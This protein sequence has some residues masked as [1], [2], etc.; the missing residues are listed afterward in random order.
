[1]MRRDLFSPDKIIKKNNVNSIEFD[2][3]ET[4]LIVHLNLQQHY[5]F[6]NYRKAG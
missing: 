3:S 4:P 1:M 5:F 6:L 2:Y